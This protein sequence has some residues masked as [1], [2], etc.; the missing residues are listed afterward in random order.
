[1]ARAMRNA[2]II[3]RVIGASCDA[4][5][6]SVRNDE[7]ADQQVRDGLVHWYQLE[8]RDL[9]NTDLGGN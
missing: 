2:A 1:M 5:L 3:T 8:E 7:E 4:A 9:E 6:V